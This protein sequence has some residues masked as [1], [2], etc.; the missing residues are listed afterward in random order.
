MKKLLGL[1]IA[2]VAIQSAF[3]QRAVVADKIVGIVGDKII[4]KSDVTNAIADAKRQGTAIPPDGECMVMQQALAQK[5]LVLQ[6]EKDSLIVSDDEVEALLD[7]QIRSFIQAYGSKDALEQIAGR[8][9]YQLKEDFR[10]PFKERKQAELMR[11][12]I[13]ENIKVTPNEVKEYWEKI[14]KDSLYFYESEIELG[15][16]VIYPKASRDIEK[17]AIDE[18]NDYKKQ[19]E[20]GARTFES[21]ARLYTDDPGSKDNGGRYEINRNEKTWDPTFLNAAFRLKEGQVSQVIKSKFGYHI[22][23]M[24]SRAGDDAVVRHILKIP[25]VTDD[26]VQQTVKQLDS[27]RAKLIAGVMT[28]GEAVSKYSDDDEHKFTG[29]MK[30]CRN[31]NYCTIDELD[32]D[33]VVLLK[34]LKVGEFSQPTPFT[35][36]RGRKGVRIAYLKTRTE[37]HQE[38]LKDDYNRIAQRALEIK[39]QDAV[40]RWFEK[41]IPTYYVMIDDEFKGCPMLDNWISVAKSN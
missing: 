37:P 22:I 19:V 33:E 18:L 7:N 38:N 4:L 10:E 3:S 28:F 20:S 15:E 14:P 24:V 29:G 31:G 26:D 27:V 34:N 5:A 6:A 8:T 32:K 25:Q 1:I 13:V 16:V 11:N 23:Q 12:K 17:L 39:K 36:Q 30:Q 41:K 9:I 21:L 2:V 35:D 40:E